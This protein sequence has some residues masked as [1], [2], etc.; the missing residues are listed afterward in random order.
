MK[1]FKSLLVAPATLGLMAPLSATANEI[2]LND[3]SKY[4]KS[5]TELNSKFKLVSCCETRKQYLQNFYCSNLR[6]VTSF[7]RM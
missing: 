7:S 4:S 6:T 3:I 5:N 1:L 2:N